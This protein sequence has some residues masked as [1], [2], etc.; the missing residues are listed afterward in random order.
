MM[1]MMLT[2]KAAHSVVADSLQYSDDRTMKLL[3][4]GNKHFRRT[5]IVGTLD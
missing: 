3:S 4:R 1:M 2:A 5:A